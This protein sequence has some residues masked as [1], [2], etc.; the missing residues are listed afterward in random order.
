[1]EIFVRDVRSQME[2][3]LLISVNAC[4]KIYA[5][6]LANLD[7][8]D[9]YVNLL[10]HALRE[11]LLIVNVMVNVDPIMKPAMHSLMSVIP[12]IMFCLSVLTAMLL[13][14]FRVA[15]IISGFRSVGKVKSMIH[16]PVKIDIP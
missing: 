7:Q 11:N 5:I 9:Q 10:A 13:S 15:E 14:I 6:R 8:R 1:M 3:C 2:M 12:S 4:L 16:R